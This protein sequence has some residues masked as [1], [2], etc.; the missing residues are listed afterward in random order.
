MH[1]MNFLYFSILFLFPGV[2]SAVEGLLNDSPIV[3][4]AD[5]FEYEGDSKN[6][7]IIAYGN[8]E[9]VQ[10][11]Q[12]VYANF[13]E[14]SIQK[15]IL[16]AEDK[17]KIL[18]TRGYIIEA[19]KVILSDKLSLGSLNKFTILTPDKATLKGK[20][21]KKENEKITQIEKGY[22]TSCKI[23]AGRRTIW[24]I[25]ATAA[26]LN[27]DE[28]S[29]TYRNAVFNFYGVP[30]MYTP[31]FFHYTGKAK[32]KSGFLTPS[33][34]GSSYLGTAVR[35]PY[36]FNIA[37]NQDAILAVVA[38]S[39]R[40]NV[41][42]GEHRY[43]LKQGQIT[44]TGSITS[45]KHY[46]PPAG[47]AMPEGGY[48]Y[49]YTTASDL[50]LAN[51]QNVGWNVN[52]VSDKNYRKDYNYGAED[53]L[54]SRIYN[55]ASQRNGF[56]ELESLSFQNLRPD[57]RSLN[58]TPFVMPH[59]ESEHVMRKFQ[60]GSHWNFGTNML[61]VHR[62]NGPDSNRFSVQNRIEKDLLLD[63]GH[64]FNFFGSIRNDI[65]YYKEAPVNNKEYT[66]TTSRSIPEVGATLS[67]PLARDVKTTKIVIEPIMSVIA[68]PYTKYNNKV[69]SEDSSN[70]GELTDG[71][72]FAPSQYSGID[73]VQNSP[74]M[75]YGTKASAF[76]I[77]GYSFSGLFGQMYTQKPQ[78]YILGTNN[79]RFSDYIGR[80]AFESSHFSLSYQ[81]KLDKDSLVNKT[82][83]LDSTIRYKKA[84]VTTSLLYYKDNQLI[85]GIKNRREIYVE[86]GFNDWHNVSASVNGRKNFSSRVD[87]PNVT[88][89]PNGFISLGG[90]V[91]Y[92][93]DCITYQANINKDYTKN[94]E[95]KKPNTTYW[96]T[97]SLKGV[98]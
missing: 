98:S 79:Q 96:F 7:K 97:I 34:G 41:L 69:F 26:E 43:L 94:N 95:G 93:N 59:F 71:N 73:L 90:M 1:Y 57:E 24:G 77:E 42:E 38:T 81:Y 52:R 11:D 64:K 49:Y 54:T 55:D 53:F 28:N 36:Y 31:Y 72:L 18:E 9:A 47:Q 63:T 76:F 62:Y 22:F 85:N 78:G 15:D 84:F 89:D 58:N 60:D 29:V 23:C 40:G 75:S 5:R 32:R 2:V 20:F 33:Y 67:Y 6:G 88:F 19:D 35:V 65:Y 82:N 66:G 91:K 74:R 87:N 61:K 30:L 48:R 68:T 44:S 70:L 27:K 8:V 92:V 16:L 50:S 3:I 51:S 13:V 10:N 21:A 17:V 46:T 56:Y 39:K 25:N 86:T 45:S 12:K 37:P 83:E 14:Y 80:L 4:E